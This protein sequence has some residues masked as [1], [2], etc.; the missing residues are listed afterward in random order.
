MREQGPLQ[1]TPWI[2]L[3][4]ELRC[5]LLTILT[6]GTELHRDKEWSFR[7]QQLPDSSLLVKRHCSRVSTPKPWTRL[8]LHDCIHDRKP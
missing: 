7:P 2:H 6:F 4:S 8:N 3:G 1:C 5:R